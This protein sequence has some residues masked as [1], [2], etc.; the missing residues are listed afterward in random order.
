MF[1]SQEKTPIGSQHAPC[2]ADAA[3]EATMPPINIA[4]DA[5]PQVFTKRQLKRPEFTMHLLC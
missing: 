4:N 1:S 3:G 2:P 5:N